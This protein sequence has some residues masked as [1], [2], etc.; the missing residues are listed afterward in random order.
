[1]ARYRH[2]GLRLTLRSEGLG[3]S[4]A[5]TMDPTALAARVAAIRIGSGWTNVAG[6]SFRDGTARW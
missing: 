2:D 6:R 1:M 4:S 3:M 5:G